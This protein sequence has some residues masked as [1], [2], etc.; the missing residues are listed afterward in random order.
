M[1]EVDVSEASFSRHVA[2]V[3]TSMEVIRN[4]ICESDNWRHNFLV[5]QHM[6]MS[7]GCLLSAN[8][9]LIVS[10]FQWKDSVIDGVGYGLVPKMVNAPFNDMF[11]PHYN[12]VFLNNITASTSLGVKL[13]Q[14][15]RR[16]SRNL[17]INI[18][19]GLT[20]WSTSFLFRNSSY[21]KGPRWTTSQLLA[22]ES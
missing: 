3:H 14:P 11:M 6:C 4:L 20:R 22:A 19:T 1:H 17:N 5:A 21:Q 18:Q 9:R 16:L 10:Y 2:G 7:I 8:Q 13:P 12:H 15:I